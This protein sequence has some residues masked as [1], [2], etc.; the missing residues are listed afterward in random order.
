MD[1]SHASSAALPMWRLRA[2]LHDRPGALARLTASLAALDCNILAL[3]VLPV[4]DGVVDDLVISTPEGCRPADL[5]TLVRSVGGRCAG[6]TK[7][8]PTD[9]TDAPAAALRVATQL[10]S[11]AIGYPEAVR[12]LLAA[13][14]VEPADDSASSDR[15]V[16][17]DGLRV[18]RGWAPFTEVELARSAALAELAAAV[19]VDLEPG[20]IVTADGAGVVLRLSTPAD[21]DAVAAMHDRCSPETRWAPGP[22]ASRLAARSPRGQAVV[23]VA[24]HQVVALG[25]LLTTT[26]PAVAEVSV[27]VEDD[28]Q[29]KGLGT[30]LLAQLSRMA[31]AA[32]H[33]ELIGWCR[34]EDDG[35]LRA[36]AQ[37][38]I[39]ARTTRQDDLLRVR[40]ES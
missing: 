33:R 8:E 17:L 32:G 20:A 27:L 28:W 18:R 25:S 5:V 21:A 10:A 30:A 16:V 38:G 26:D 3:T 13:D 6:I 7:A 24:G 35:L 9:L 40:L 14:S 15:Q 36:A 23:A 39:T 2:E 34:P 4:P 11:G 22:A 37:A 1:T 19:D 29:G 12:E 31:R